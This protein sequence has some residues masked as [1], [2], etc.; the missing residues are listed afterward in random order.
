MD[1]WGCNNPMV[2]RG[3]CVAVVWVRWD[4][5]PLMARRH[6]LAVSCYHQIF[7]EY[8]HLALLV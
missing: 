7:H 4:R 5:G 1:P 8:T 3:I 6:L 2:N